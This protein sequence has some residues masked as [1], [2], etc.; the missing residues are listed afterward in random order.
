MAT[1]TALG[2]ALTPLATWG[3]APAAS[4]D[5]CNNSDADALWYDSA[6]PESS[7]IADWKSMGGSA[8]TDRQA[9]A[10]RGGDG[11][12]SNEITN[13]ATGQYIDISG[14]STTEGAA[15]DEWDY[16]AGGNQQFVLAGDGNG[17][18][19][20]VSSFN[21]KDPIEVPAFSTTSGT[22]LDQWPG[23]GGT[24]QEWNLVSA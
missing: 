19:V 8:S 3:G 16:W 4:A 11:T 23:N 12:Y 17:N 10:E 1:E 14:Q 6:Y 21:S 20:T 15:V 9:A 2:I 13:V 24:S 22:G 18:S 5:C 7:W